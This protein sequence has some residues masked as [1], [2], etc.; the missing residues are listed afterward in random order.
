MN[1]FLHDI[2]ISNFKSLKDCKITD[3]KRIN[4]FIGRPNVGKSN[5]LEAL[6]SFSIPFLKENSSKA[7]TQLIRLESETELFYNGNYNDPARIETNKGFVQFSY[8]K[9]TGLQIK[10]DTGFD[11]GI[12][13]IDD[14]LNVRYKRNDDYVSPIR[15]YS[16]QA[17]T[18]QRKT[19]SR[20]LIPPFGINMF[21]MIEKDEVLKKEISAL[22]AEYRLSLVFDRA[23]QSLKIMQ[24]EDANEIF[25]VPYNS[26]ADTLQRIIFFKTAVAS[27]ND[28]VLLFEEPEAHSFP[29]YMTHITQEMIHKEDNQYFVATHSPFILNDFLEN[30]RE[31]L[32][33]YMVHY[34]NHET[35]LRRLADSELHDIYQFGVDLFTNSESYI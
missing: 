17:H 32:A 29:P 11:L 7:L 12:Y 19:H 28:C 15:K 18:Q 3:C 13:T 22:F 30:S 2:S 5:I 21:N 31:E 8:E 26:I 14:K 25:L 27:N 4:L 33:V 10:I 9:E 24:A 35:R 16:F 20:Y 6:S 1:N 23:S 34:E